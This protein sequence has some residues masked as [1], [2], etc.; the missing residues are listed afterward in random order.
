[1][2]RKDTCSAVVLAAG[3]GTRMNSTVQKQ[4][5]MLRDKPLLYY[6]LR[7]FQ[8]SSL[9]D[10]IVLVTSEDKVEYC[11]SEVV[12]KYGFSK[13][14]RITAG[15][16]ERYDSVYSGLTACR[17]TSEPDIVFIHDSA[18]PFIAEEILQRGY[19]KV[20]K[21]GACVVAVPSKDTVKIADE[22]GFVQETPLRDR[23]W[24]VQTPQIFRYDLLV[25]AY[26][27]CRR[28]GMQGI[29]DDAMVVERGSEAKVAFAMGSYENI[30]I[31]T[32]SDLLLAESILK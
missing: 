29:T 31:T 7:C 4:F 18:R 25:S 24:V 21:T 2:E 16:K 22:N 9:I 6:S 19:D 20:Q 28:T 26:E 17:E 12:E 10:S 11:R 23:V 32:P 3:S 13:V 15:G 30:K 5:L 1:M 14:T 8:D 27:N